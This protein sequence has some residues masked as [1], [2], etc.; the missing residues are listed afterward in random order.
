M[1]LPF[2]NPRPSFDKCKVWVACATLLLGAA[3]P[4]H[5]WDDM[6]GSGPSPQPRLQPAY[7]ADEFSDSIGLSASCSEE[8]F[9]LGIRYYREGLWDTRKGRESVPARAAEMAAAWEKYGVRPMLLTDSLRDKPEQTLEMIKQY[10]PGLIA[11]IEGGNEVNNKFPPQTLNTKYKGKTDEAGGAAFMDDL[12][13]LLRADPATKDIPVV[14]FDAIFTDYRLAKPH[15]SFDFSNIH[16]YQGSGVPSSS[17]ESNFTRFNNILPA[18]AVIK[19]FTPTEC[20]YNVEADKA[21]GTGL[22]GSLQAQAKSI[23]MLLAEYFRHGFPRTYLFA[24][25]NAD[26]YG[27]LESNRSKRPSYFAVKSLVAA[28]NDAKWNAQTHRW[29]GGRNF[30]P[31]ALLFDLPG[32]PQGVHTLVLQKASGEYN[33]LIWNEVENY[34][35]AA[36]RDRANPPVP[37]TLQFQTPVQASATLLIPNAT[38]EYATTTAPVTDGR[39]Q[40][41]VP[42]TVMIVRLMPASKAAPAPLSAPAAL[43]GEA[44]ENEAKLHWQAAPGA[45]GYFVFR[46]GWHIATTTAT[47]YIDASSW[48]RPG[49]GYT[50]EVQAY[51]STGAMSPRATQVV[52]TAARLPD[53]CITE[54]GLEKA[55]AA[56]GSAVRAFAKVKNVGNGATPNKI[57]VSVVWQIDGKTIGWSGRSTS[58]KPGEEWSLTSTDGPNKGQWTAVEGT[59]LLKCVLDDINRLPGENKD[60]NVRDKTIVIG[61]PPK[62]EL[63]GATQAAPAGVDLSAEGTLDWV[64]WGLADKTSLN[65]KAGA[66]LLD[67]KLAKQ[68]SG[69]CD[70]SPGCSISI[71]WTGGAP[72]AQAKDSHTGLWWNGPGTSQSFTAAADTTERILRVYVS[73]IEGAAGTLTATLSDDSAP[74]YVSSTWNGN[75]A[76]AWAAVPGGFSAVYTI[77]YHA[78]SADQKLTVDWKLKSEPNQFLGQARL[79][80]ATLA[81]GK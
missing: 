28:V 20:G 22:T 42:P 44:S 72:T 65:R 51:A 21:N 8:F 57:S 71:A 34:D 48:L 52:Q 33:L 16:S 43:R 6:Y 37:V 23:P 10:P 13:R 18:G 45:A 79:Q 81:A 54:F 53:V 38:G 69:Y 31:Q 66:H 58:M 36:K 77:R 5:A 50:Y 11:E 39:L 12:L 67:E 32:A 80:A 74:P 62:G 27:L 61:A 30:T 2:S 7:R 56:P 17:L 63:L 76:P 73:G 75:Q 41:A 25:H 46:N 55:D 70:R 64:H 3:R 35:P 78:A 1:I 26:G 68:G 47:E 24:L 29:E 19:P 15:T 40:I 9:D 59:H 60:N 49:L 4:S 14:A